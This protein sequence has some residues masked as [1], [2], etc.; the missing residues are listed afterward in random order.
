L[1]EALLLHYDIE[2]LIVHPWVRQRVELPDELMHD[3][4]H[5]IT[6]FNKCKWLLTRIE[7]MPETK[8]RI[9][10]LLTEYKWFCNLLTN[11]FTT[12][13]CVLSMSMQARFTYDEYI[14][15]LNQVFDRYK[16]GKFACLLWCMDKKARKEWLT[17][18]AKIPWFEQTFSIQPASSKFK[19]KV[20]KLASNLQV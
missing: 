6:V 18:V 10:D 3:H 7:S 9:D 5:L 12:E 19:R 14:P 2:D 17:N 16:E 11:L 20:K 8:Q 1:E 15:I 13:Q 4:Y